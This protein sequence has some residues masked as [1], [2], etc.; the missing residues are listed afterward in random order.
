[1][2]FVLTLLLAACGAGSTT[3][4]AA[5]STTTTTTSIQSTTTDTSP[6]TTATTAATT[7]SASLEL[8]LIKVEDGV[9]TEGLDTISV[10]V[11][12][13]VRF[14]VEADIADEVHVHGYDLSFETIP[15]EAVL[16]EFVADATGIFEVE[17]EGLALHIV[18]IE[19]TP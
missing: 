7:T 14:E 5:G 2:A 4:T 19:V 12:E 6:S 10:R 13:T 3:T 18:G 1:M 9:K 11:G 15:D 16:V 8:P 17:I